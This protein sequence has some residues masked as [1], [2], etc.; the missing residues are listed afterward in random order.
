[1]RDGVLGGWGISGCD[2][3]TMIMMMMGKGDEAVSHMIKMTLFVHEEVKNV[4]RDVT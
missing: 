4:C 2:E 1:M 3:V